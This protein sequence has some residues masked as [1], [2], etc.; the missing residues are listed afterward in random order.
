MGR[1]APRLGPLIRPVTCELL[2]LLENHV[3]DG[4]QIWLRRKTNSHQVLVPPP[5]RRHPTQGPQHPLI[6]GAL[7]HP[8]PEQAAP[9][10]WP[11]GSASGGSCAPLPQASYVYTTRRAKATSCGGV[12]CS[13]GARLT[14]TPF[15]QTEI[16][17]PAPLEPGE[18]TPPVPPWR[19][20]LCL[21][22][23][24]LR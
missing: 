7:G 9:R 20:L 16:L 13:L 12:F 18:A 19:S 2:L 24:A 11:M 8:A 4:K 17:P 1:W 10:P 14:P 23:S 3:P 22:P 21:P 5:T 15:L 6:Y